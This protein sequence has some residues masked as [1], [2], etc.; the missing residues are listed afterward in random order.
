M[1]ETHAERGAFDTTMRTVPIPAS[2]LRE[3]TGLG[4]LVKGATRRVGLQ[5]CASCERR[6]QRLD[7]WVRLRPVGNRGAGRSRPVVVYAIAAACS[8]GGAVAG[9]RLGRRAGSAVGT[10]LREKLH[11]RV[12]RPEP[13]D[14]LAGYAELGG[15]LLGSVVG[16]TVAFLAALSLAD[17][18]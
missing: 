1:I 3:S 4:Q 10:R 5:P 14:S 7:Q 6:A 13:L 11:P 12:A 18:R 17:R 15:Q 2:L 9:G 16:G 8:V